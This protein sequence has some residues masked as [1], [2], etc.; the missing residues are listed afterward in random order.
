MPPKKAVSLEESEVA[1]AL[2][3][4]KQ[5]ACVTAT[6]TPTHMEL[7]V[8]APAHVDPPKLPSIVELK[9]GSSFD[10][11]AFVDASI[12]THIA[13]QLAK[14]QQKSFGPG[15]SGHKRVLDPKHTHKNRVSSK[16]QRPN[17]VL[18]DE[19]EDPCQGSSQDEYESEEN[20]SDE[21]DNESY[22]FSSVFRVGINNDA[23][24]NTV[25]ESR[26][27]AWSQRENPPAHHSLSDGA[28]S[29]RPVSEPSSGTHPQD[30][31]N[32][33]EE[34]GAGDLTVDKDLYIPS[35]NSP[36]WSPS[37]G[38]MNWANQ[39]FDEE[40]DADKCKYYEGKFIAPI[41]SRHIFTPIP[42]TK[43]M[44]QALSSQY[45]KDTD[46]FF[47]RRETERFLFRAS[48]DICLA[49]GPIFDALMM[50][51]ERGN[52][53]TERGLLSEGVLGIASA[54]NR[55]TRA[56]R[57]LL[58]R[59]FD[60]GVAK[61]LYTFDPSHS[62]FFGGSSLD[63]RV[64]EAKALA[65]ARNNLFFRPKPKTFRSNKTYNK[66]AGFQEQSQQQKSQYKRR[67][68]RGR[69]RGRRYKNAKGQST[70]AKTS[71]SK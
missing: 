16:R 61:E 65:E 46:K 7:T 53:G 58:R 50:L 43:A 52:C 6:N 68:G 24:L 57:E 59:Y 25:E 10:L 70:A 44:D 49:Y 39:Y 66:S 11:A 15:P 31:G 21:E 17:M 47:N 18:A 48:K 30:L 67:P 13:K 62:Q 23:S 63:D 45:T 26:G 42:L 55:I 14:E 51:G 69:G 33:G 32:T 1:D 22:T 36:N 4:L 12:K 64:K 54:M 29:V 37:L 35:K 8:E 41:E 28:K 19:D 60:L 27:V 38:I 20:G 34:G 71:E 40:W 9:D 2:N 56:R 3:L 5:G